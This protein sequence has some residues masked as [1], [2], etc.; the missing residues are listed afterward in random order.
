MVSNFKEIKEDIRQMILDFERT[1]KCPIIISFLVQHGKISFVNCTNRDIYL[2]SAE[3]SDEEDRSKTI[4]SDDRKE[5]KL[6]SN[7]ELF[8]TK[9]PFYFG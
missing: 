7:N 8:E 5:V 3:H 2:D 4:K 6:L 9:Q 1:A